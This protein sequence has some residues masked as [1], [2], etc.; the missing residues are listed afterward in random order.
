MSNHGRGRGMPAIAVRLF[1][2]AIFLLTTFCASGKALAQSDLAEIRMGYV[3]QIAERPPNLSNLIEPPENEGF[4]GGR[5]SVKDN[6]TTGR[7]LKQSFTLQELDVPV[8]ED[9]LPGFIGMM[10]EG[11]TFFVVDAPADVL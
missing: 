8:G 2:S 5:L 7:F 3:R 6:N 10:D 11:V 1:S 9:A 4:A